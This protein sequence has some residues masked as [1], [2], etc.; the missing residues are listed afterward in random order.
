MIQ[1]HIFCLR[2]FIL[3]LQRFHLLLRCLVQRIFR[4]SSLSNDQVRL[5]DLPPVL[6]QCQDCGATGGLA[7]IQRGRLRSNIVPIGSQIALRCC[8]RQTS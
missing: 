2:E 1:V 7:G 5:P 4:K 6:R 8:A 3:S